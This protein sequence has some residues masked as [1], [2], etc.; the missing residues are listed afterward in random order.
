METNPTGSASATRSRLDIDTRPA[1]VKEPISSPRNAEENCLSS[2]TSSCCSEDAA[3]F[4][5]ILGCLQSVKNCIE[6]V[7][8]GI[9]HFFFPLTDLQKV[10]AFCDKWETLS[11]NGY[12][13]YEHDQIK[14]DWK[15]EFIALPWAAKREACFAY[16]YAETYFEKYPQSEKPLIKKFQNNA[17]LLIAEKRIANEEDVNT[18][19][20]DA[21]HGWMDAQ[22]NPNQPEDTL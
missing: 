13:A 4:D 15:R 6:N 7:I 16:M 18:E 14:A 20:L 19:I 3:C 11:K 9:Y 8:M 10:E 5:G 21:L 12:T 17:L 1:E 22:K 2:I